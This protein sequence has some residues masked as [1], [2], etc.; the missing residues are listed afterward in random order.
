MTKPLIKA[1][2]QLRAHWAAGDYRKALKLAAS[3]P[4]LGK[5]KNAIQ[6]G[7]AAASNPRIY[8]EMGKDVDALVAKGLDAIQDR[9]TLTPRN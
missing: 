1:I 7:W 9:Y 8:A 6:Q 5:H 2:D 4:R 3:W